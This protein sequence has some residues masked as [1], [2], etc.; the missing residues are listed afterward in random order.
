MTESFK[1]HFFPDQD[2]YHNKV[3][4]SNFYRHLGI[5]GYPRLRLGHHYQFLLQRHP[6]WTRCFADMN[7]STLTNQKFV[8]KFLICCVAVALSPHNLCSKP[9]PC[10]PLFHPKVSYTKH[11]IYCWHVLLIVLAAFLTPFVCFL[12]VIWSWC[13]PA[14]L[15]LMILILVFHFFR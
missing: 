12:D 6:W 14:Y 15:H 5:R 11:C 10:L 8:S 1:S 4:K 9:F 3:R 2:I 13:P 7:F